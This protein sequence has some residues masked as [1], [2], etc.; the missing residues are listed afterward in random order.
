VPTK[1]LF[2]TVFTVACHVAVE[3]G[4]SN[5]SA[6]D[7]RPSRR[8]NDAIANAS[9]GCS[10]RNADSP[11]PDSPN[12]RESTEPAEPSQF[13]EPSRPAAKPVLTGNHSAH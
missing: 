2:L 5:T 6:V 3:P 4:F 10:E 1:L 7:R 13:T 8:S 11:R 12:C 9:E